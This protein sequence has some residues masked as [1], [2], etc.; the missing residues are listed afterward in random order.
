MGKMNKFVET[1]NLPRLTENLTRLFMSKKSESVIKKKKILLKEKPKKPKKQKLFWSSHCG[2]AE[3]IQL[4]TM[5]LQVQS[6]A[7]LSGL[8]ILC[9]CE[10][11]CR[12]KKQLGSCVAMAVTQAGWQL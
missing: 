5:R 9:C 4:V 10:L 11:W 7:L 6:L 2:T 1:Y 8:R 12:S 3:M